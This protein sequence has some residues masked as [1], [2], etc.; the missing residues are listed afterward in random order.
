[1]VTATK[2]HSPEQTLALLREIEMLTAN[3]KSLPEA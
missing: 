1:M 3:G 2:R